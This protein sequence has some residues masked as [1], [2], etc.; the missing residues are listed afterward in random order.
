MAVCSL[1]APES[2]VVNS[3]NSHSPM[4]RVRQL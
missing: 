4:L 2:E 3:M 1:L